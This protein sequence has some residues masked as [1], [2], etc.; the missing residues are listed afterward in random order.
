MY[1]YGIVILC[2]IS[3]RLSCEITDCFPLDLGAKPPG[4][5]VF[6]PL[7][8]QAKICISLLFWNCSSFAFMD[9]SESDFLLHLRPKAPEHSVVLWSPRQKHL[10]H[11][12]FDWLLGKEYSKDQLIVCLLWSPSICFC[13]QTRFK[14]KLVVNKSVSLTLLQWW[15]KGGWVSGVIGAP[16]IYSPTAVTLLLLAKLD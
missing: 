7:E 4:S 1:W 16:Q 2:L 5:R 14:N 10:N 13:P 6:F 9:E 11:P 15:A 12:A 8:C 3:L